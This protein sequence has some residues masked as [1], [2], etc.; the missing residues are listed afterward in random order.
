MTGAETDPSRP[1]EE[2]AT[3]ER[4]IAPDRA[5]RRP[6]RSHIAAII[7]QV[8]SD[9]YTLLSF[10]PDPASGLERRRRGV[11]GDADGYDVLAAIDRDRMLLHLHDIDEVLRHLDIPMPA[12]PIATPPGHRL[13]NGLLVASPGL[14]FR[15]DAS[16]GEG[17]LRLLAGT[18]TLATA[19]AP[20]GD[21]NVT[22]G[23]GAVLALRP[24]VPTT[25]EV[26]EATL[27]AATVEATPPAGVP[28]LVRRARKMMAALRAGHLPFGREETAFDFRLTRERP[29][30]RGLP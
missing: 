25:V 4:V 9:R 19:D 15:L 21:R 20:G 3:P 16:G 14:S 13:R 6:S 24:G 22:Y 26:G 18:A 11:I 12:T 23:P 30:P 1:T 28:S 10:R 2:K 7:Q 5:A 8:P 17:A 29:T 27:V